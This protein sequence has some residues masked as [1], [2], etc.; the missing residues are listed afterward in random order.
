MHHICG[1]YEIC[2]IIFIS[3]AMRSGS[4]LGAWHLSHCGGGLLSPSSKLLHL[5]VNHYGLQKV[6]E[7]LYSKMRWWV[8]LVPCPVLLRGSKEDINRLNDL[9]CHSHSMHKEEDFSLVLFIQPLSVVGCTLYSVVNSLNKILVHL[10]ILQL[11]VRKYSIQS[12]TCLSL[13]ILLLLWTS[14]CFNL[15]SKTIVDLKWVK[16]SKYCHCL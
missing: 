6:E 16:S 8:Q 14:P 11:W 12:T 3:H 10:T 4:A 7:D 9:M 15:N 1:V 2:N 5:C 13:I